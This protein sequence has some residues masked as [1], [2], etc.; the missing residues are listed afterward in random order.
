MSRDDLYKELSAYGHPTWS[1]LIKL[2][3]ALGQRCELHTVAWPRE[4]GE[5]GL[6]RG[7]WSQLGHKRP[8]TRCL[9]GH[10]M[11]LREHGTHD[12]DAVTPVSLLL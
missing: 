11:E 7:H 5:R 12:M 4:G 3:N 9:R 6:E 1:T 10:P 8:H 2:A